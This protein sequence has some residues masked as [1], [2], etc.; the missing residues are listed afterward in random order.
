MGSCPDT[1]IDPNFLVM[2]PLVFHFFTFFT[3]SPFE[4]LEDLS[5]MQHCFF[6]LSID[7]S[8]STQINKV[9]SHPTLPLTVTAHED[10]HIR[11]FDNNTGK[12]IKRQTVSWLAICVWLTLMQLQSSLFNL[13]QSSRNLSLVIIRV[14]TKWNDC[15]ARVRFVSHQYDYRPNWTTQSLITS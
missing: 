7:N 14:I 9:V 8:P 4:L 10:R 11:F 3:Y 1:D 12:K 2:K 15:A 13:L 6:F 5:V